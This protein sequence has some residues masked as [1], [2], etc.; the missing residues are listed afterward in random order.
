[1][2]AGA[3]AKEATE[4]SWTLRQFN[5]RGVQSPVQTKNV[6]A[7]TREVKFTTYVFLNNLI[8]LLTTKM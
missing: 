3:T 4:N 5:K 7:N 6:E 2:Q 8:Y 1:M